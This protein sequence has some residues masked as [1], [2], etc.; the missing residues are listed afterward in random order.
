[1]TISEYAYHRNMQ[2]KMMAET[3]EDARQQNGVEYWFA[4]DIWELLGYSSWQKFQPA[5]ERAMESCRNSGGVVEEHFNRVV[6]MIEIANGAKR[7]IED[8]KLTRYACYLVAQNGDPKIPEIAFA[9]MYFAMQT[10]KQEVLAK[11]IEEI[12]RMIH[13]KKLGETEREFSKVMFESGVGGPGIA[14]IRDAGDRAFFG[15]KSTA[16]MKVRLGVTA[17]PLADVLPTVSLK[18]KDLATEMTTINTKKKLLQGT[19]PIKNEHMANSFGVRKALTEAGI[20]PEDLPAEENIK[21][22]E[23]R[24][25]KESKIEPPAPMPLLP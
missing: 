24:M 2:L 6:K 20:Y 13:R 25:K 9:Q 5:L 18:A 23:S 14:E 16:T 21:K 8:M 22:V 10:R 17:G 3:L 1:M 4:R 19:H 12:E 7:E 11:R 15:G